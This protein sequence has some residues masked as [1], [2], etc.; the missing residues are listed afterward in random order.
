[1]TA[2]LPWS[3]RR[4]KIQTMKALAIGMLL[5]CAPVLAYA[6]ILEWTD[7]QG[8]A[9]YTNLKGEVPKEDRDL[10][11]VVVDEQARQLAAAPADPALPAAPPAVEAPRQA[12]V[13][14]DRS[15]ET[16]AF[17]AGLTRGLEMARTVNH[18]DGGGVQ[19]NGPLAVASTQSPAA[20]SPYPYPY[21]YP[22]VTTS[23]DRGR[24]RHQTL[25]MLLQDQFAVDREGPFVFDRLG[26]P[27]LNVGLNPF[28]PRGLPYGF[29]HEGRIVGR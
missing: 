5:V 26:L 3:G 1:M 9:H 12:D 25:R 8:I 10:T 22:F 21:Y 16:D 19:I 11:H 14:Y 15:Q 2:R 6:D 27:P 24:S 7:A 13:V 18:A 23:F 17:L 28:L 4:G 29:P 20:Y